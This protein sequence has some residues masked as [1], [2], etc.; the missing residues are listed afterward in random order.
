MKKEQD[1]KEIIEVEV[2]WR[3]NGVLTR[4]RC[5]PFDHPEYI[6]NYMK[7][8]LKVNPEDYGVYPF[9]EEEPVPPKI[10]TEGEDD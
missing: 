10:W 9:P 4:R 8:E 5:L 1:E 6:Y 2:W 7:R 3:H